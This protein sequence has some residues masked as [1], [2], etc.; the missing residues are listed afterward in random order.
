MYIFQSSF[1]KVGDMYSLCFIIRQ[2]YCW[3][4]CLIIMLSFESLCHLRFDNHPFDIPF[5]VII[6]YDIYLL[7]LLYTNKWNTGNYFFDIMYS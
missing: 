6:G 3:S 7:Y 2:Y 5:D 4:W 1:F